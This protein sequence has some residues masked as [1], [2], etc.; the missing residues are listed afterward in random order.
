MCK[1]GF[2]TAKDIK[3]ACD[4]IDV[5]ITDEQVE[6]MVMKLFERSNDTQRLSL[7]ELFDIFSEKNRDLP[8][9]EEAAKDGSPQVRINH[10]VDFKS[11]SLN[12]IQQKDSIRETKREDED[13]EDYDGE[14]SPT[15][16]QD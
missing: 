6:Y 10:D 15:K 1:S 3:D 4:L 12:K 13:D 8:D 2:V 16:S 11:P 9:R 14:S 7:E 5:K